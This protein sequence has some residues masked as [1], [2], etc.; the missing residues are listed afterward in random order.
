MAK[1]ISTF[2][3]QEDAATRMPARANFYC[4]YGTNSLPRAGALFKAL[5]PREPYACHAGKQNDTMPNAATTT[6][7]HLLA[8]AMIVCIIRRFVSFCHN[9]PRKERALLMPPSP[10]RS[11]Q[12]PLPSEKNA[13]RRRMRELKS[14]QTAEDMEAWSKKAQQR[15][16]ESDLW[17]KAQSVAL[18]HAAA[19]EIATTRLLAD[20]WER[21]RTVFL[22]RVC[23][24]L[25]GRMEFIPCTRK[26]PLVQSRFGIQEPSWELAGFSAESAGTAFCPDLIIVPGLAFDVSGNRL[27]HGGGYYDRFLKHL[28]G[29]VRIGLCFAFQIAD[30]VPH[31]AWDQPVHSLCTED[32]LLC[33]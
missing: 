18:F 20:L 11:A 8:E 14:S 28:G 3:Q 16:I 15:L 24:G 9:S 19:G 29:T 32:K 2:H 33:L 22:P 21:N 10:H 26:T 5:H 27:G 1:P 17:Q 30:S 25:Q 12:N 13:L 7:R 4:C 31:C 23:P 6:Q